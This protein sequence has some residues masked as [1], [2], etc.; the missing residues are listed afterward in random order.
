MMMKNYTT[1]V[2][3]AEGTAETGK[4]EVKSAN[5]T[6]RGLNLK[7]SEVNRLMNRRREGK[8]DEMRE[9]SKGVVYNYT[10]RMLSEAQNEGMIKEVPKA[11]RKMKKED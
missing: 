6:T 11:P 3:R 2:R 8:P 9:D 10:V 7:F 4:G 1:P 5:P